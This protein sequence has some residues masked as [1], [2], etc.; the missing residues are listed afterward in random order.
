[1]QRAYSGS[2]PALE[3]PFQI[4]RTRAGGDIADSIREYGKRQQRRR[5]GPVADGI[6]GLFR[7]LAQDVRAERIILIGGASRSETVRRIAPGILGRPVI[8]PVAAQH[9]AVGAARQAAWAL[10]GEADPPRWSS[11]SATTYEAESL[12]FVRARYAEVCDMTASVPSL[13]GEPG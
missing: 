10:G 3:T 11:G 4:D 13:G 8:V 12:E 2:Q 9:V 5:G 7:S 6:P 1:M